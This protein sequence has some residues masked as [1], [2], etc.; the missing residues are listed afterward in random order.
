LNISNIE[1][2]EIKLKLDEKI[3]L[4][5]SNIGNIKIDTNSFKIQAV[6]V[7]EENL[8]KVIE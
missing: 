7:S 2:N 5:T 4:E 1:G 8:E 6:D 3:L